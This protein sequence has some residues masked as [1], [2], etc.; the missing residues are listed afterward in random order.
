MRPQKLASALFFD[1][2]LMYIHTIFIE[3]TCN[4]ALYSYLAN[5]VA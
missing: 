3:L 5:A 2:I 1:H 4:I